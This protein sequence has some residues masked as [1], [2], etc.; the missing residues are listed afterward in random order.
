MTLLAA[1]LHDLDP[2][3]VRIA[4]DLGVRWYGLAYLAGFLAAWL[5]MR[6]LSAT[7]RTPLS[8]EQVTDFIF[9]IMLSVL[10][11]G[12]LGYVLIYDR[13]LLGFSASPPWWGVLA[14]N[15]GG[16]A[17]HG[18]LAG[19]LIGCIFAGRRFKAPP[20]HLTDL[21]VLT[22][23]I[24]VCLGRIANFINGELLGRIVAQPGE[25]APWWAVKYPQELLD[26]GHAPDLTTEQSV[27]LSGLL[28]RF[29]QPDDSYA[30]AASRLIRQI[31]HGSPDLAAE[32]A[33]L[34]SARHPSQL[35]QAAAEG[36]LTLAVVW[37]IWRRPRRP[38]VVTGAFLIAY[39]VA[40]FVTDYFRLPDSHLAVSKPA[41]LTYGQWLSLA[42]IACGVAMLIWIVRARKGDPIGG[43]GRRVA[44]QNA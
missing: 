30:A 1:W 15:R 17:S 18:G 40:R 35:Y 44:S 20:L 11:G 39:G 8:R 23:P 28:L 42:V 5:I 36:M 22:A 13:S 41:G 25:P 4:G 10:V 37:A 34:I 31:Q 33:P 43:W 21:V 32:L 9:V 27:A 3:V 14:I 26:Q 2:Y 24:G 7:S 29:A 12:R 6:R 38:G 16:M 19:L